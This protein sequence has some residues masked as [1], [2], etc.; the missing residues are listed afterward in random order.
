MRSIAYVNLLCQQYIMLYL[1]MSIRE[2]A[3]HLHYQATPGQVDAWA[4]NLGTENLSGP[5]L[6]LAEI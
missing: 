6:E 2:I 1:T 5:A 4:F 3:V